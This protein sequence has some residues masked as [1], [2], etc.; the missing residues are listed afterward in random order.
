ML[1]HVVCWKIADA[2]S[3]ESLDAI[4]RIEDGLRSLVGTVPS[5]RALDVGPSVLTGPNHWDL[6]LI[7][8]FDNE[9]GLE[10]YQVHPEHKKV[11]AYIRSVV[12]E[13]A[14][15]DFVV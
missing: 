11:G 1:K 8:D 15:V 13:Q 6:A 7:V 4:G 9:A 3:V 12:S 5:I 2:D 14:T 10:E